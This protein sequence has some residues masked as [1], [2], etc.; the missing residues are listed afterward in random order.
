[1]PYFQW[2]GGG[3]GGWRV[4]QRHR[5]ALRRG[6]GAHGARIAAPGEAGFAGNP[7]RGNS[8]GLAKKRCRAPRLSGLVEETALREGTADCYL[9]PARRWRRVYWRCGRRAVLADEGSRGGLFV[10]RPRNGD[11]A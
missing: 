10:V 3:S 2:I 5:A 6:G 11:A 1:M 7:D 8:S 4:W 9:P